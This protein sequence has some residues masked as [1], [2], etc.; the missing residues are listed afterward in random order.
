MHWKCRK[1]SIIFQHPRISII[2]DEVVLPDGTVTQYLKFGGGTGVTILAIKDSEILIQQEYSYPID[3]V[4]Y[5]FP[6]GG[7]KKDESPEQAAVREL[8]EESGFFANKVRRL[9][10]YYPNNRRS[11]A[12]MH[13]VLMEDVVEA[14]KKGGDKEEKI[15]SKWVP[16]TKLSE[17]IRNGD[18]VNYSMLAAW[19]MYKSC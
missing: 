19:A 11:N 14:E 3:E 18:I 10:W 7:V 8:I 17:M 1:S 2:E 13:V 16:E 15:I 6:G 12:M 5:Q 9:G 4:L